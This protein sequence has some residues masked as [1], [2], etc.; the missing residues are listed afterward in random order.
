L[1]LVVT[2]IEQPNLGVL[3][4]P[5]GETGIEYHINFIRHSKG[6]VLAVNLA[7]CTR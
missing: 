7:H 5:K 3:L 4:T 6:E 2:K 1:S